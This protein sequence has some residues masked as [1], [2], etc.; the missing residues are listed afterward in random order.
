MVRK[1]MKAGEAKN[2]KIPFIVGIAGGT[3]S[4]KSTFTQALEVALRGERFK[5]F[6]MDDYHLPM[7]QRTISKAPYKSEAYSDANLPASFD[8]PQLRV[9]LRNE[10]DKGAADIIIV[11]GT[12]VLYDEAIRE[13]LNLKIFVDTRDDERSV[14]YIEKYSPIYGYD[15][16]RNSYLDLA[17]YRMDE[18]VLPTKWYADII[19]NGSVKSRHSVAAVKGYILLN[20]N[21]G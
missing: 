11:E 7:E 15:F 8:I 20:I 1:S 10:I 4:G 2:M 17:R 21:D 12:M 16:I 13:T 19:L 14:R 18:F 3:Q 6:H 5:T 9:D